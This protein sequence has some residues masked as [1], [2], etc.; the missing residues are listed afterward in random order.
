MKSMLNWKYTQYPTWP[1]L[2]SRKPRKGNFVLH[3]IGEAFGPS[4]VCAFVHSIRF[5]YLFLIDGMLNI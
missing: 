5:I 2:T 1:V 3:Q 4:W